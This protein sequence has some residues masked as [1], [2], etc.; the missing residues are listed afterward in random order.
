MLGIA[1][2]TF[3]VNEVK[4]K[5]ELYEFFV[6]D[7]PLM[8]IYEIGDLD[9]FF[10]ANTKWVALN[11]VVNGSFQ[12]NFVSLL[13]TSPDML[14]VIALGSDRDAGCS[15][16]DYLCSAS[17]GKGVIPSMFY[18]HLRIGLADTVSN[19]FNIISRDLYMKMGLINKLPVLSVNC[20]FVRQLHPTD[21]SDI[22]QFYK[23]SY[24]GNWFDARM[25]DSL[26]TF[27]IWEDDVSCRN[28]DEVKDPLA[29][30]AT[31]FSA[32]STTGTKKRRVLVAVA[33]IHVFSVKFKVAA[34]GNIAVH[35]RFRGRGFA[36]QVTAA[37]VRSLLGAG[38]ESIGLNV[39]EANQAAITC[40]TK[41]GFEKI[42]VFEEILWS[43]IGT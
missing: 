36:T 9:D 40:Y 37:L 13:Y 8:H 2:K 34:L 4:S 18:S 10:W 41:L 29:P 32:S 15:L 14:V 43:R 30:E 23:E 6:S 5:H 39:S 28:S 17:T 27:G 12:K 35:P 21:L 3:T 22:L 16:L 20:E 31:V 7:E 25:L 38:I 11:S 1:G 33:G 26:Q 42:D 19:H 24:P